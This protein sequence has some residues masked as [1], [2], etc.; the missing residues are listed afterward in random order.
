MQV[1]KHTVVTID[2]VLTD[3]EGVVID[4]S[5]GGD[6]LPYVHGTG[7]IIAGL[8]AALEGKVAGDEVAVTVPPAEGYGER[9]PELVHVATRSQFGGVE[10]VAVGM[11]FRTESAGGGQV[12]TVVAVEGDRVVLDGNH[13]L[14]G[15]T[16]H[17]DVK[18][19][20]VRMATATEIEEGYV[21][22]LG[23]RP[24]QDEE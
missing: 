10:D 1:G 12:V 23:E 19:V 4:S 15:V 16:L 8:E 17:F 22:D 20:E 5:S 21:R 2:Y 11:Q 14:A 9:D 13:P 3:D 6:P 24:E 7:T 18:V